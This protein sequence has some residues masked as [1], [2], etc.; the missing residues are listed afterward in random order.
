MG[1][2]AAAIKCIDA[3][4]GRLEQCESLFQEAVGKA[5]NPNRLR[6]NSK[7]QKAA[8]L[9]T[10][11]EVLLLLA[12]TTVRLAGGD[13][14][15]GYLSFDTLMRGL[16]DLKMPKH[17]FTVQA[18]YQRSIAEIEIMFKIIA[19]GGQSML[20]SDVTRHVE[21]LRDVDVALQIRRDGRV[22][23][24]SGMP[25]IAIDSL[26]HTL[27][28]FML[29]DGKGGHCDE[30]LVGEILTSFKAALIQVVPGS[31]VSARA[32]D[33]NRGILRSGMRL[34]AGLTDSGKMPTSALEDLVFVLPSM[35]CMGGDQVVVKSLLDYTAECVPNS[36]EAE[37]IRVMAAAV[38]GNME[39]VKAYWE[40]LVILAG[41]DPEERYWASLA[42]WLRFGFRTND[43]YD[44]ASSFLRQQ[45]SQH[46][47]SSR[48]S[49]E[50]LKILRKSAGAEASPELVELRTSDRDLGPLN[51][52]VENA[53]IRLTQS[54]SRTL[55]ATKPSPT[56]TSSAT[57]EV[58]VPR[59]RSIIANP[60]APDSHQA[61]EMH[62]CKAYDEL[63]MP[64]AFRRLSGTSSH[65]DG[66]SDSYDASRYENWKD[67]YR[68]LAVAEAAE[69]A[70]DNH[71]PQW[72]RL[73][74][75]LKAKPDQL[76]IDWAGMQVM[77]AWDGE[78]GIGTDASY[79]RV[80]SRIKQ[81]RG[82]K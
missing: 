16:G 37:L 20:M 58:Y 69:W 34:I 70:K 14:R 38:L 25:A 28:V 57:G 29:F 77:K 55:T 79:E 5:P 31:K 4:G 9:L 2:D 66:S 75:S 60:S 49:Q 78:L 82:M 54:K 40:S 32:R 22:D 23:R 39:S 52:A 43:A 59:R 18:F 35:A 6:A 13:Y 12:I 63:S 41:G 10:R 45:L 11:D 67:T 48:T 3:L 61:F 21:R 56:F 47:L 26:L 24:T 51:R 73:P 68:L 36:S 15:N 30:R 65:L 76:T 8:M 80:L 62:L 74:Q 64:G 53:V 72:P 81:L 50:V 1:I 71:R 27:D 46:A 17:F 42:R 19:R 33:Y 7:E 44:E